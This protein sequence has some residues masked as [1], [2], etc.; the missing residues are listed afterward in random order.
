MISMIWAMGLNNELGCKNRMPWH[1]PADFAYFKKVT[2]GKTIIMGRKTFES[3]GKPLAGRKN[4]VIT[5]DIRY[6][7]DGCIVI[8]SIDE[9]IKYTNEDEAFVIG[10]AE[11]Y[12]EFLPIADK[13]YITQ[14]NHEFE[15]DTLFPEI[16]Y[17]QWKL[18]SS[19]SGPKDEKNPYEYK[20][21][22]Y[23]RINH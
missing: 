19:E 10:G 3:L 4:I 9:A 6:K 7:P 20:W 1:I 22:V 2:M 17:S 11:I 5:R 23:E 18:V 13:L 12:K 14:I 21:L 16:E 8:N 15:A